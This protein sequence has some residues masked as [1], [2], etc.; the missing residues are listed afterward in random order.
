MKGSVLLVAIMIIAI[1]VALFFV[2]IRFNLFGGGEGAVVK[3][4]LQSNIYTM[5]YALEAAELYLKTSLDY[6]VYQACSENLQLGGRHTIDSETG[7]SFSGKDYAYLATFPKDDFLKELGSTA[8]TYLNRYGSDSYA[9]MVDYRVSMPDYVDVRIT[10]DDSDLQKFT[11]SAVPT[12][13][14]HQKMT[15]TTRA[16]SGESITLQASSDVSAQYS[17]P[18]L[19]LFLKGQELNPSIEQAFENAFT[20]AFGSLKDF[21]S[22]CN[23][24]EA[25][26]TEFTEEFNNTLKSNLDS[27]LPQEQNGYLIISELLEA[28][29][30]VTGIDH[31]ED[32]IKRTYRASAI[33]MVIIKER[34]PPDDHFYPIWDGQKITF[35]PLELV[36]INKVPS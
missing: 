10:L 12:G 11:A 23:T 18:C 15:I 1:M 6:S 5:G 26:S 4:N 21:E 27:N 31:L 22:Q 20:E 14:P 36:F 16:E 8:K 32:E 7:V 25:C 13:E 9:F 19:S 3:T 2:G 17:I 29:V 30:T 28:T 33:Q 35:A 34:N 24:L